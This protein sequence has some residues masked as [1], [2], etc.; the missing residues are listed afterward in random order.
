MFTEKTRFVAQLLLALDFQ[1][2]ERRTRQ[3]TN[4]SQLKLFISYKSYRILHE[5]F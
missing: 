3:K 2:V 5:D 1:D 4:K